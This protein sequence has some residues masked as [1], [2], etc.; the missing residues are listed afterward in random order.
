M[1]NNNQTKI[2]GINSLIEDLKKV[3]EEARNGSIKIKDAK[4]ISIIAGK[5]I[6]ASSVKLDY[7]KFTNS[8]EEIDFLK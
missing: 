4:D 2:E 6:K 8:S 3:Y 1:S 5:L 7:N